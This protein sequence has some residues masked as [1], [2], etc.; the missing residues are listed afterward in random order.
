MS[1][2]RQNAGFLGERPLTDIPKKSPV[3]LFWG[4]GL[5]EVLGG[6]IA[7]PQRIVTN[8]KCNANILYN[9]AKR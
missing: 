9:L 5:F 7:V 8:L 4:T 1:R 6:N 3:T 2:R